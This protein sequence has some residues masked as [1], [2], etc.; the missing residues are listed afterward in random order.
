MSGR[1]NYSKA[2]RRASWLAVLALLLQTLLPLM[3][4]PADAASVAQG[5]FGDAKSIC[6]ASGP[7]QDTP[8]DNDKSPTHHVPPCAIC[9]ALQTAGGSVPP[10][11]FVLV[12]LAVSEALFSAAADS[13]TIPVRAATSSQPRA[14]PALV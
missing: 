14:P 10:T 12:E 6:L 2:N 13:A 4:H 8:S 1:K 3:H 5:V 7:G 11:S 9:Q